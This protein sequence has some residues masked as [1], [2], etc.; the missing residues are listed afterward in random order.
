MS[1]RF[2][3]IVFATCAAVALLLS[4][5]GLRAAPDHSSPKLAVFVVVDQM[6][7]DYV[8]RFQGEWTGGFKRLLREGAWFRRAAYPYLTTVT[9]AGHATV[10]T[11]AYPHVHGI[12]QNVWWD[13]ERAKPLP[14]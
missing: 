4:T 12:I 3:P 11:G 6:R 13:R 1:R 14:C 5:S 9:C 10:S 8:D 7:A 2:A